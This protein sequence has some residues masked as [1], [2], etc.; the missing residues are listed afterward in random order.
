M[1]RSTPIGTSS[2]GRTVTGFWVV[3]DL[4]LVTALALLTVAASTYGEQT[5][6]SLLRIPL[7][8]LFVFFLPGYAL[9]SALFPS[10]EDVHIGAVSVSSVERFVFS[11]GLSI[12]IVPLVSIGLTMVSVSIRPQTVLVSLSGV[13][14]LCASL[15][16]I[17]RFRLAPIDR[18]HVAPR[19]YVGAGIGY[20]TASRLN[21]VL[22]FAIVLSVSSVGFLVATAE[23]GETY[24]EISLMEMDE[25]GGEL[26]VTEYPQDI[27]L[28]DSETFYVDITNKERRNVEYTGVVMIQNL[29]QPG[30]TGAVVETAELD[31]FTV[32]LDHGE[33]TVYEHDFQP[34]EPG[35]DLKLTYLLYLGEPPAEPTPKNAYRSVHIAIDVNQ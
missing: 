30:Q 1:N 32:Q 23:N 10:R 4:L 6:L 28:N 16:T 22:V 19:K 15:A 13:V 21:L 29:T 11:I 24:T 34:T 14:V 2:T 33:Q 31:R 3:I 26:V 8:F 18:F 9:T 7:G 17:A 5:G 12:A 20:V 25:D 35:E 27:A